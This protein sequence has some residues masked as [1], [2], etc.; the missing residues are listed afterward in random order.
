VDQQKQSQKCAA[1]WISVDE[2]SSNRVIASNPST[3]DI[4]NVT[5]VLDGITVSPSNTQLKAGETKKNMM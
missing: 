3:L 4:T 1:A 5:I 2:V